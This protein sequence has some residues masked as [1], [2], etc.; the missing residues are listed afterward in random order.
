MVWEGGRLAM[1]W[2]FTGSG[3]FGQVRLV[4]GINL[5]EAEGL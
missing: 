3:T 2:S 5:H 4:V 1:T